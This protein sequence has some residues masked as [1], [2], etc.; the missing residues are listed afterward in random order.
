MMPLHD[1][2]LGRVV[3]IALVGLVLLGALLAVHLRF[4]REHSG[5][6]DFLVYW[7]AARH[8]VREGQNPYGEEVILDNQRRIYG[9]PAYAW[10]NQ[11]RP[12]YPFHFV[13]LFAPFALIGDYPLARALW[14]VVNEALLVAGVWFWVRLIPWKPRPLALAAFLL[15]TLLGYF[16]L[17]G[18]QRQLRGH[19]DRAVHARSLRPGAGA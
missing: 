18:L 5:G 9:R 3:L 13:F 1:R 2:L 4:A 17:R 10:E 16:S 8:F 7:N 19:A 14:M 15:Y 6:T 12:I 11:H